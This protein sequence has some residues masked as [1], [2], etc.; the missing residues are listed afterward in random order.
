MLQQ[1]LYISWLFVRYVFHA[2]VRV[3]V[4]LSLSLD[5]NS[6]IIA[7]HNFHSGTIPMFKLKTLAQ[8]PC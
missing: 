7:E 8:T 6:A 5:I 1:T 4:G 3:A 2:I